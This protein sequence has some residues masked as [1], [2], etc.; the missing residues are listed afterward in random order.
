VASQVNHVI[1]DDSDLVF[2]EHALPLAGI[3]EIPAV[4]EL[5]IDVGD[6]SATRIA[7]RS[8]LLALPAVFALELVDKVGAHNAF[9]TGFAL[10][11]FLRTRGADTVWGQ[12]RPSHRPV[13][14][15]A[16]RVRLV[17]VVAE[18]L[19]GLFDGV[20]STGNAVTAQRTELR[21]RQTE[22]A[23]AFFADFG[24]GFLAR[25]DSAGRTLGRQPVTTVTEDPGTLRAAVFPVPSCDC[26]SAQIAGFDLCLNK[27]HVD[28]KECYK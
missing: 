16:S 4:K 12:T 5:P 28:Q 6:R 22:R 25:R 10:R 19:V 11:E 20:V 23:E 18:H 24:K 13:A 26:L 2:A 27:S 9:T 14:G 17:T 1:H 7:F 3:A 15:A 8:A 21:M